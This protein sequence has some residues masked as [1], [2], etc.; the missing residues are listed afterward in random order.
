MAKRLFVGSLP[1]ST[2]TNQLEELFSAVGKVES[3]NVITDKFSGQSKGFGFVEMATEEDA[4]KAIQELNGKEVDGRAMVV[5]EARPQED[6]GPRP[7]GGGGSG[8]GNKR[9]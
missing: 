6:R 5:N 4:Q 1:Y 8:G 7:G 2:T 9:W 3:V